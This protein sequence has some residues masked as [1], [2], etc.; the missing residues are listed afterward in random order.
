[1]D[2][3]VEVDVKAAQDRQSSCARD[4][5][6][7]KPPDHNPGAGGREPTADVDQVR[8]EAAAPARRK[9]AWLA[10]HKLATALPV[11][12]ALAAGAAG[13]TWWLSARHYEDTDDAFIDVRPSFISAQ[14]AAPITDVP[15]TDN[16][17]V[18]PGQPLVRLDDRDYRAAQAQA[19]AQVAQAEATIS[20]AEAQSVVQ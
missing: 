19:K 9:G 20:S 5:A 1:L 14:V 3:T 4:D 6:K 18:Q 8:N 15:V 11:L 7:S 10:T 16:E 12:L 2:V 17:I 13:V